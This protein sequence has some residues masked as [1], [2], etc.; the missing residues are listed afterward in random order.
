M[1]RLI[2]LSKSFDICRINIIV[3]F[4]LLL[5]LSIP[6]LVDLHNDKINNIDNIKSYSI[7]S[8]VL[9]SIILICVCFKYEDDKE[10]IEEIESLV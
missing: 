2:C 4:S 10:Y 1:L 7:V 3:F 5:M 6:C 8:I 9:S